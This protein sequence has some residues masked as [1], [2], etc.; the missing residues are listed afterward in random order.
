MDD[1]VNS[2]AGHPKAFG[3]FQVS[4]YEFDVESAEGPQV[5]I[6]FNKRPDLMVPSEQFPY[7]IGPE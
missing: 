4:I 2:L 7:D 1:I 5:R 3:I 6:L